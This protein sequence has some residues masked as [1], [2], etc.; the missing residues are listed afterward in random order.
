MLDYPFL[1]KA[2]RR[3]MWGGFMISISIGK[4]KAVS[5]RDIVYIYILMKMMIHYIIL[6]TTVK[7]NFPMRTNSMRHLSRDIL[8][9]QKNAAPRR[10]LFRASYL[11]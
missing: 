4:M 6:F 10:F 3:K 7:K 2:Q 5:Y 11:K 1:T 9:Y 8:E